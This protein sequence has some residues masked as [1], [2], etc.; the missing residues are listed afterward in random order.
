MR[1]IKS[2]LFGG[3]GTASRTGDLVLAA[4]RV[5]LALFLIVGH[6]KGKLI[7]HSDGGGY[8]LGPSEALVVGVEQMGFPQPKL[9][10]WGAALTETVGAG[11]LALGLLTRPAALALTFNMG[12]AA[13]VAHGPHPWIVAPTMV[14]DTMYFSV[15]KEFAMLYLLP[16]MLFAVIGAGHLSLDAFLRGK[17]KSLSEVAARD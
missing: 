7:P 5:S 12:V 15:G 11:L 8:S 9:F 14:G 4:V 6:G 16:F 3:K 13:F 2:L 1:L 10:A 17:P